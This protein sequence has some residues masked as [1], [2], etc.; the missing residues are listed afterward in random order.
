MSTSGCPV[1]PATLKN[2]SPI[3]LQSSGRWVSC[4]FSYRYF[5]LFVFRSFGVEADLLFALDLHDL[6]VMNDDLHGAIADVLD[7]P[8]NLLFDVRVP[9][10]VGVP[11]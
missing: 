9:F 5:S 7:C 6:R 4:H 2:R 1:G 10:F 11:V 8:K 3:T